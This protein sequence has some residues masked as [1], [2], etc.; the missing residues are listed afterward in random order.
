MILIGGVHSKR[1]AVQTL[2]ANHTAKTTRMVGLARGPK[3]ALQNRSHADRT[4]LQCVQVVLLAAWLAVQSVERFS[5]Q[6]DLALAT[7][8]A[9]YMVY[10]LH[11]RA[12]GGFA[13]HTFATLNACAWKMNR[14]HCV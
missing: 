13:D 5:L 3:D 4:F 14:L 2:F 6:I 8:E 7:G 11:G 1:N 9:R 12:S 10:L